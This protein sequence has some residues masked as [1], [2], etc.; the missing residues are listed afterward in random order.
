MKA[1][2]LANELK[3]TLYPFT[4]PRPYFCIPILTEPVLERNIKL[5]AQLGIEELILVI[6]ED[7]I[8]EVKAILWRINLPKELD[9]ELVKVSQRDISAL[10][11][12]QVEGST[13]ILKAGTYVSSLKV[14]EESI[15]DWS[16]H[17]TIVLSDTGYFRKKTVMISFADR[18]NSKLRTCRHDFSHP[19]SG[20]N[21]AGL[22]FMDGRDLNIVELCSPNPHTERVKAVD[23][24][25]LLATKK[26]CRVSIFKGIRPIAV[27]VG[28]NRLQS[29]CLKEAWR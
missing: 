1:I 24:F 9:Y 3:R 20:L 7:Y 6:H 17:P 16:G 5:L 2:I 4:E 19:G 12:V 15:E 27:S 18:D 13:L 25:G 22:Y 29:G 10:K 26:E 11:A 14:L 23:L 8:T 28:H 21:D